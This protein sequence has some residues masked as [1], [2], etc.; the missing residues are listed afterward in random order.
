MRVF[1]GI[2]SF[3]VGLKELVVNLV[4]L[5][6]KK[7]KVVFMYKMTEFFYQYFVCY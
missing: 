1:V 4:V 2:W 3:D 5:N 6:T 7:Y